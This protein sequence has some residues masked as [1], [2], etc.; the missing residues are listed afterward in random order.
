[1]ATTCSLQITCVSYQFCCGSWIKCGRIRTI[2]ITIPSKTIDTQ[3][4]CVVC[5]KMMGQTWYMYFINIVARATMKTHNTHLQRL[6]LSLFYVF[7]LPIGPYSQPNSP[8]TAPHCLWVAPATPLVCVKILTFLLSCKAWL[9][10]ADVDVYL[11]RWSR[12]TLL[13]SFSILDLLG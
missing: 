10:R 5:L 4:K 9:F 12:P 11:F 7:I 2:I 1:M 6:P 13:P 3:H 8:Q